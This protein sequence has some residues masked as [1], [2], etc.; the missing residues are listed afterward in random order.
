MKSQVEVLGKHVQAAKITDA[1][2]AYLEDH[3]M[4]DIDADLISEIRAG[5]STIINDNILD[6]E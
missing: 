2:M 4:L 5:L 3:N 6:G 1:V